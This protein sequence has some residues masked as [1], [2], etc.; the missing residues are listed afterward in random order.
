MKK[1]TILIIENDGNLF[2]ITTAI[3]EELGLKVIKSQI[4]LSVNE[5]S[6]LISDVPY[7][8]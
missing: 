2:Y 1:N 6:A 3:I 8:G 4:T 5:I 7:N